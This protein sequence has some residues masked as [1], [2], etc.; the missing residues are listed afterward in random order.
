MHLF[1]YRG[2]ELCC[3]D[4]PVRDIAAAVGTPFYLYSFGTL[5]QHFRAFDTA[6]G[7][8]PHLTCFSVKA[9]SNIAILRIFASEGGGA[10]VVSGGELFRALRA[11]VSANK[12]VFAGVGKTPEEIAAALEAGILVFNVESSQELQVINEVASAHGA[13]A[14]VALRVNPDVDPKTDPYV[15]TGLKESKFGIDIGRAAAE[16]RAVREFLNL[17]VAGV[18]MHIGSQVTH[19]APFVESLERMVALVAELRGD[20]FDIKYL[21]VG[22]G[23]GIAYR[24]ESP[25]HPDELAAALLPLLEESGCTVLLEPGRVIVGNA[26]ILVTKVLY[27]KMGGV[28]NYIVVDAGMNDLIRPSLYRDVYHAILPVSAND[29]REEVVADVVGPICESGDFLAVDRAI[30]RVERGQLLAVM[31]AGAYGFSMSSNYNSRPRVAEVLVR[32]DQFYVIRER[33]SYSD[34]VRGE[35]VPHFLQT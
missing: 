16:F 8:V 9:N 11:G 4:V 20:G 34:L 17:E 30:P 35:A 28:K 13:Q 32:D 12:I 26:G 7:P 15:A 5:K 25:P 6:F 31:S 24:D 22:G 10:D 3:E 2:E 29:A 21:D 23:L 27:T 1:E 18:H 33:E 14:R 19:V